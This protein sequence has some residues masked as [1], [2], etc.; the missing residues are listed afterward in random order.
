MQMKPICNVIALPEQQS[1]PLPAHATQRWHCPNLRL[2]AQDLLVKTE[3][4]TPIVQDVTS[5]AE[6]VSTG[7]RVERQAA[8]RRDQAEVDVQALLQVATEVAQCDAVDGRGES[9]AQRRYID[10][11]ADLL[12]MSMV[13]SMAWAHSRGAMRRTQNGPE[14]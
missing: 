4:L 10:E 9:D 3:G 12:T 11:A 7:L 13:H 5:H 2:Q 6:F 8:R 14:I 1:E